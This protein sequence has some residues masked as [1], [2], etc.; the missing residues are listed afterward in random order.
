MSDD[1]TAVDRIVTSEVVVA[2]DPDTAFTAFTGELDLW[3]QRGP[4]NFWSPAHRVRAIVM[5]PHV[6]GRIMEVLT[7]D[8]GDTGPGSPCGSRACASVGMMLPT[9]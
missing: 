3:W 6:G 4:I 9:T 1:A 7:G 8:D 2:C 5:E